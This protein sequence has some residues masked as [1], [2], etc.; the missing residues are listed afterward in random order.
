MLSSNNYLAFALVPTSGPLVNGPERPSGP[1]PPRGRPWAASLVP[2]LVHLSMVVALFSGP[3][4][5][6]ECVCL[7]CRLDSCVGPL[8]WKPPPVFH[9]FVQHLEGTYYLVSVDPTILM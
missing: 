2:S 6:R 9:L 7:S 1:R 4:I 8:Y 3:A 5:Q